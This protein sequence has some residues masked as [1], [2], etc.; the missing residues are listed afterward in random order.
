MPNNS[1]NITAVYHF[2]E[3]SDPDSL[4]ARLEQFAKATGLRGLVVLG[5]EGINCTCA[6]STPEGLTQWKDFLKEVFQAELQFKDSLS[7]IAPFRIFKVK[8]RNEIVTAGLPGISP[9]PGKNHHLSPE[10]WNKV[11]KEEKDVVCIDTRNWYEYEI[12]SFT[13]AVNPDIEKFTEFPKWL[14]GQGYKKEQKMLIF[15][16]GGIRCEK[17]ILE[18]QNKGYENVYQLEG[19]ILNYLE[20][21]PDDQFWGECFVFDHRVSVDQKL[22]PSKKYG[23]CPHCG[24]PAEPKVTCVRCGTVETVC[25]DCQKIPVK[26]QTCSK[27][28]AHWWTLKPGQ[29]GE[30]QILEF[31]ASH[32]KL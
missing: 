25:L 3:V 15:C 6:S 4:Q 14:E 24:N 29:K 21:K 32:Q 23:L 28:C 12:G 30:K 11:L 22:Q 8:Q 31:R 9:K 18:L 7:E 2:S 10:E 16:T 5:T 27:N 17:G 26:G 19:G 1:W 20:K 13:N